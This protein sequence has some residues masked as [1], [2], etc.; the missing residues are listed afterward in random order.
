MG[1][2]P[3]VLYP[4]K[5]G[6]SYSGWQGIRE[7]NPSGLRIH[8]DRRNPDVL[9]RSQSFRSHAPEPH[10]LLAP[11]PAIG[12]NTVYQTHGYRATEEKEEE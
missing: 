10:S 11:S 7:V 8:G 3:E 9:P 6:V 2:E 12:I 5:A 1:R 4:P